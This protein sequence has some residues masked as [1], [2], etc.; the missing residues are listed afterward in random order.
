MNRSLALTVPLAAVAALALD[1]CTIYT[2]GSYQAQ[3]GH[4]HHPH[5]PV[6]TAPAATVRQPG[7]A[8]GKPRNPGGAAPLDVPLVKSNTIFG[9]PT[10]QAFHGFLYVIPEGTSRMPNFDD[11]VP[12]GQL[13]LDRFA[14]PGQ[15]F[16]GGFPGA[17]QQ[18]E[19][20]AIKYTGKILVP[21]A[22]KWT[23]R[24]VSDD[25][26]ILYIDGKKVADDDGVHQIKSGVGDVELTAGEHALRLDYF[27]EKRGTVTLQLVT[28]VGGQ[29]V[30]VPGVPQTR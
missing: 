23:F 29:E 11:L 8:I 2:S 10:V 1:G 22:G 27:Q 21:T 4:P 9:G 16:S 5:A 20:F 19:W 3:A 15:V 28:F 24:L 14:V 30:S 13:Y 12:F 25:G 7:L 18:D 6:A 26:A 17:L